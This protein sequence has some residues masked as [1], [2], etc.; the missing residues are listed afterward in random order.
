[1]GRGDVVWIVVAAVMKTMTELPQRS[2]LAFWMDLMIPDLSPGSE[3]ALR[4][5]AARSSSHY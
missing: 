1:M 2:A 4:A 3:S 5:K